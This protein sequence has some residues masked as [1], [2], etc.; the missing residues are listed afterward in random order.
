MERRRPVRSATGG[1]RS[2]NRPI[3]ILPNNIGPTFY[4]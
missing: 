2:P 4:R 3:P 1:Q